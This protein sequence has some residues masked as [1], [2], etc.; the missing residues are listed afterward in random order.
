MDRAARADA[1]VRTTLSL[2][3]AELRASYV[4][5]LARAWDVESL[6]RALD[7]VCER[8]EQAEASSREALVAIVDALNWPGMEGIVQRLRE[9]AAGES[10]L[11][12]ERL[13]RTPLRTGGA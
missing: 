10:L 6:A 3:D 9:Q 11:A 8:A 7:V 5:Y 12:L 4:V 2:A 1:L 13:V